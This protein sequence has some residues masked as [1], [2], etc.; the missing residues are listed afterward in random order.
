MTSQ[1]GLMLALMEPP[2]GLGEEFADWY[3]TEHLP[4]RRGLPGFLNGFRWVAV[5]GFPRS[6]AAYDLASLAALDEPAYRAVSGAHSTP[7]SRRLLA[8]TARGGRMRVE[9]TQIWPGTAPCLPPHTLSRLLVA[10]YARVAVQQAEAFVA[11]ARERV[12]ALQGIAQLR[13]FASRPADGSA[14]IEC[15]LL[16]EFD[17][18]TTLSMLAPLL[19]QVGGHGADVF[20]LYAP[21]DKSGGS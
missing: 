4:Q 11:D 7:W 10:R 3:D 8:R 13:I 17:A 14:Q 16:I 19:G 9:V 1:M 12:A 6:L 5:E 15:W 21:W 20:N 2:A 18:P